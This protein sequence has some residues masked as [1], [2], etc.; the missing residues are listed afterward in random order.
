MSRVYPP[1]QERWPGKIRSDLRMPVIGIDLGTT[2]SAVA[3]LDAN[4]TPTTILNA[5]GELT[6]PSAVLFEKSGDIVVGRE[7]RRAALA[8]PASVAECVKRHIG[9]PFYPKLINGNR[10][11]PIE[12]S[13]LILV[14]LIQDARKKVGAVDG[15]VIT[16]PAYFD[17]GRRQATAQA[18]ALAGV[19]VIDIINEPTS[20]ALAYAYRGF[21][22]QG[23]QTTSLPQ[24]V[25]VYDLGGG[26]FDVTAL[27]IHGKNLTVLATSG[28]V[29]LGGRDWDERLFQHMAEHFIRAH[30]E[31]P[32][33]H[34][35]SMQ[36]LMLAAEETK[37]VLSSRKQANYLITHA[38]KSYTGEI[39]RAQ[40]EE[41]TQDLL[42][43]SEH[44]LSRII[45]Q[46]KLTWEQIDQV[47]AVGGSTRMPQVQEMLRRVTGKEPDCSLSP[48]EAVAQGAAI[49]AAIC[50]T[51]RPP[52]PTPVAS[53]PKPAA[54][55]PPPLPSSFKPPVV[56]LLGSIHTTNVNAHTLGV[57]VTTHDNKLRVSHLV[58]HNTALPVA[59]KKQ[60]GTVRDGQTSVTVRIVEGESRDPDECIAVG[61][62]TIK[63]LP[64]NLPKGSPVEVTF[65]YDNS[66]RLHV[67]AMEVTGGKRASVAIDRRAA[68]GPNAQKT[69]S[70]MAQQVA[71]ARVS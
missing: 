15:V 34:P 63:P 2:F 66:G 48:D 7:A 62:C 50:S 26:T 30:G 61:A 69:E 21:S 19:K 42:F 46:A 59:V 6:T 18:G 57:V 65:R 1:K 17:E 71:K 44:R 29:R 5:E 64:D 49:H 40:F 70:E 36:N 31:D 12:I 24:L 20:A 68:G 27:S 9:D 4:G 32:R 41:L 10:F 58:P 53:T 14:K 60:F 51:G 37:K 22:T 54:V 35:V 28:D 23:V 3:Y 45:R 13:A 39:T 11:S 47:L 43:R 25:L 52:A 16:V 55:R 56:D 38:G 8:E 67:E 33:D